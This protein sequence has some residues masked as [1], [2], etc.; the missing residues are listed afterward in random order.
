[1]VSILKKKVIKA[2]LS[3]LPMD[4]EALVTN[5]KDWIA[6]DEDIKGLQ[7]QIKLKR[8]EKRELTDGL[9][10]VMRQHEIDCFDVKDGKLLYTRSKVKKPLS[11]KHLLAALQ[12]Y[13]KGDS[14]AA[15]E[16]SKFVM[17]TRE[18]KMHEGIRRKVKK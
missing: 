2:T 14:N 9:V 18:E 17:N 10:T 5:I 15:Q 6:L 11:K 12:T 7:R 4:K 8:K 3:Y 13:F 1:M 16:V